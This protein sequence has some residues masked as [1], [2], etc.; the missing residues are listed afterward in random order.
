MFEVHTTS[1]YANAASRLRQAENLSAVLQ[2][3]VARDTWNEISV[4]Q[5]VPWLGRL[6][7]ASI[8]REAGITTGAHLAAM[9]LCLKTIRSTGGGAAIARRGCWPSSTAFWR[10]PRSA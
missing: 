7:A 9:D 8:L 2:A 4:L 6:H 3:T 5:H 1:Q 10:P